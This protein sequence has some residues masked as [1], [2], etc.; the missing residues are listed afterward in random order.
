[1]FKKLQKSLI[2]KVQEGFNAKG[3]EKS[4][5]EVSK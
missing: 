1:M 4:Y 3:L 5:S 2:V